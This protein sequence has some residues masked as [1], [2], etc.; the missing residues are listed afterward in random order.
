MNQATDPPDGIVVW[1]AGDRGDVS[2]CTVL[3]AGLNDGMGRLT[4]MERTF[5]PD[6]GSPLHVHH[7]MDEAW[8]VLDGE[9]TYQ[10]AVKR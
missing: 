7:D 2:P 3:K 9:L 5:P 1:S 8:Y 4:L 10:S 6:A